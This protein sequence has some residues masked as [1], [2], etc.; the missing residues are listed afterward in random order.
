MRHLTAWNKM[1]L[2]AHFAG[3]YHEFK[4]RISTI[5]SIFAIGL[6]TVRSERQAVIDFRLGNRDEFL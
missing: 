1:T 3:N 5:S 2:G 4:P 6:V